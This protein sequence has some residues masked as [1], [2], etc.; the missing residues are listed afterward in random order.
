MLLTVSRLFSGLSQS[1][2]QI[3]TKIQ[4]HQLILQKNHQHLI[5]HTKMPFLIKRFIHMTIQ[6]HFPHIY[7]FQEIKLRIGMNLSTTD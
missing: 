7:Y 1:H 2:H 4:H 6:H 3:H 5:V